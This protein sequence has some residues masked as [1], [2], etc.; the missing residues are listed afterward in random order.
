MKI[1]WSEQ[2]VRW[3]REASE[4]TGYNEKMAQLLLEHIPARES[5]CDIGC[6]A[7][8]VDLVLARHIRAVTCVDIAP[9]PLA[10]LEE[11]ARSLGIGNISCRCMDAQALTGRWD[12]VLAMF[13]GGQDFMGRYFR[14]AGERMILVTHGREKGSMGPA[15]HRVAKTTSI[16]RTSAYLDSLGVRYSAGEHE[17]EHGQPL[18]SMAEARAFVKAYSMPVSDGQ[19]EGYLADTL[20]ETGRED[21]P[22]YLP[23]RKK[24]GI[25]VIR[26]EENP[27]IRTV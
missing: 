3:F 13:F 2:S 4:Y 22:L 21:Y 20:V 14:L 10:A 12:T 15:G 1:V 9:E 7:G 24:F 17:L 26:R 6:G 18:R 5:L 8:M 23:N 19:L 25:F 27:H 16:E 11:N